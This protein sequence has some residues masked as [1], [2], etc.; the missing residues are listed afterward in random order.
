MRIVWIQN[1]KP[2]FMTID[3]KETPEASANEISQTQ[4]P[5]SSISSSDGKQASETL[6]LSILPPAK[7]P[8]PNFL[9]NALSKFLPISLGNMSASMHCL[10]LGAIAAGCAPSSTS[11]LLPRNHVC[12]ILQ[13]AR[14]ML[15]LPPAHKNLLHL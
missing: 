8:L 10:A 3:S 7:M 5:Q 6:T 14:V 2:V 13:V 15:L 9:Q 4:V 11:P 12:L 1:R